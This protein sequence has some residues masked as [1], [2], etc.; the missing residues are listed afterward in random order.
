LIKIEKYSIDKALDWDNFIKDEAK[1]ATFLH[2]RNFFLHNPLNLV[3]DCSLMFYKQSKLIAVLPANLYTTSSQEIIFHSHQRST[4]GGFIIS[5]YVGV[6]DAIE[7]VEKTIVF[8]KDNKVNELII[9]NPFRIFNQ[10][11]ADETDYAMWFYGFQLKSREI[12]SV[13]LL[14]EK[15]KDYYADSTK[16]SIKKAIKNVSIGFSDDFAGYWA[17]LE[18]NLLTNHAVQPIHNMEQFMILYSLI[19]EDSI[20]LVTAQ[21]DGKLIAGIVLFINHNVLHAQYIGSDGDFQELRPVN[22]IIDFIIDWGIENKFQYF[23]LG[24]G[25]EEAGRKIN[26]GLFNFKEGFGGRGVLRETMNLIL[27]N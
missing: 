12:E 14:N 23:N 25:N 7:I 22:G 6:Q 20:K 27:K 17:V 2:M 18:K 10:L 4:Y 5:K 3:D 9:R 21:T 16:R 11:P 15:T 26:T 24:S 13:I 1:N 19:G 8:A